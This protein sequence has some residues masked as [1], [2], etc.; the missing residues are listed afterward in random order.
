MR[1]LTARASRK[2]KVLEEQR[3]YGAV[4]KKSKM[5]FYTALGMITISAFALLLADLMR[6]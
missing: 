5:Y 6:A 1:A 3:R 2:E 4:P